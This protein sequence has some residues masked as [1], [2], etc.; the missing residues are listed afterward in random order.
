MVLELPLLFENGKMLSFINTI[1][2]VY[3]LVILHSV[4]EKCATIFVRYSRVFWLIIIIYLLLETGTNM[5]E[6]SYKMLQFA[7][8]M[9][10]HYLVKLNTAQNS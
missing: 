6:R 7:L 9:S 1:I 10:E 3:W 2:V 5:L 8:T 4:F